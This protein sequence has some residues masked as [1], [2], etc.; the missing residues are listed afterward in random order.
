MFLSPH[1]SAFWRR[2]ITMHSNQRHKNAVLCPLSKTC[3]GLVS[4]LLV[5]P[6]GWPPMGRG[7]RFAGKEETH[8]V[9]MEGNLQLSR[10]RG[11]WQAKQRGTPWAW[12]V[13]SCLKLH[14]KITL[15]LY[16]YTESHKFKQVNTYATFCWNK[17]PK[18]SNLRADYGDAS[19]CSSLLQKR[20]SFACA[21]SMI[22]VTLL[23]GTQHITAKALRL[24]CWSQ[25]GS[26]IEPVL[27]TNTDSNNKHNFHSHRH[28]HNWKIRPLG[29][30]SLTG[31]FNCSPYIL[32][33][34]TECSMYLEIAGKW[35]QLYNLAT[36][37]RHKK[38]KQNKTTTL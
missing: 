15:S 12:P 31:C 37:L 26:G 29:S 28:W 18:A 13:H 8:G 33:I 5:L 9:G 16:S 17:E 24:E 30:S 3:V 38:P 23:C 2:T 6:R 19:V 32:N 35:V 10:A 7:G 34:I 27:L 1:Y 20:L 36:G 25:C 22:R 4:T 11:W 14:P 21:V